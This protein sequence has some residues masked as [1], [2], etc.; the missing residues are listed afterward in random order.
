MG[1]ALIVSSQG[2]G[3]Y[4]AKLQPDRTSYDRQHL[5]LS[6][7]IDDIT[8]TLDLL[9]SQIDEAKTNE[10][11][12][13]DQLKNAI[14][15]NS[16]N[17]S[18]LESAWRSASS[19]LL[20]L[21]QTQNSL[22]LQ[23]ASFELRRDELEKNAPDD[24]SEV[25]L[26]CADYTED[27]SG[28][29]GTIDP[30]GD[31]SLGTIIKPGDRSPVWVQGDGQFR[32]VRHM[33]PSELF[34]NAAMLPAWQKWT[35]KYRIGTITAL[36]GDSCNVSLEP[37]ESDA[38]SINVNQSETLENV[39]ID[40]MD[41]NGAAF[42]VGDTCVVMFQ[43]SEWANPQV[44][45]FESNPKACSFRGFILH[46]HRVLNAYFNPWES[47]QLLL[48]KTGSLWKNTEDA[49]ALSVGN[50][51][52]QGYAG[53]LSWDSSPSRYWH[54]ENQ[55]MTNIFY[56]NDVPYVGDYYDWSPPPGTNRLLSGES[57]GWYGR[58]K[59]FKG[60]SAIAEVNSQ[61]TS[62]TLSPDG[63]RC[64]ITL[65]G[66]PENVY[67]FDIDGTVK[68]IAEMR[69]VAT[70]TTFDYADV[71]SGLT[72]EEVES[73]LEQ[74]MTMHWRFNASG[75]IGI[76]ERFGTRQTM[77]VDWDNETVSVEAGTETQ[78]TTRYSKT[79]V[80]SQSF[81]PFD[82]LGDP[83]YQNESQTIP[84]IV[85]VNKSIKFCDW[86]GDDLVEAV[87]DIW[88]I[89]NFDWTKSTSTEWMASGT[90]DQFDGA[91]LTIDG[92]VVKTGEEVMFT[93]SATIGNPRGLSRGESF[94]IY[95]HQID[96]R[97]DSYSI[98]NMTFGEVDSDVYGESILHTANV[99][100]T[101][102]INNDV[103]TISGS[104]E[105]NDRLRWYDFEAPLTIYTEFSPNPG[106]SGTST[107]E[108]VRL[109]A[110]RI[111][112]D[113]IFS[114]HNGQGVCG[115]KIAT[116]TTYGPAPDR[117]KS[118]SVLAEIQKFPCLKTF[119]FSEGEMLRFYHNVD[120]SKIQETKNFTEIAVI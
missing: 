28:E 22:I 49:S 13:Y 100:N 44:I 33:T 53:S 64:L 85:T 75:T 62:A 71:F 112:R 70:Y 109:S 111:S 104:A 32:D 120:S 21:Q 46:N 25:D 58:L 42:E 65:G 81:G 12:A 26:W 98:D 67:I 23:K 24:A 37:V 93:N 76:T 115:G 39:G 119:T 29:V 79:S 54:I 89:Q 6:N 31:L 86:K 101:T 94:Q 19:I 116:L 45:G 59:V 96:L 110:A 108:L 88:Q 69:H 99:T 63:A 106:P 27:L 9:S 18:A 2:G 16:E 117:V 38:Q 74:V 34:Y 77:L 83:Y 55:M 103:S 87:V 1:K 72:P 10:T 68:T 73:E 41:C 66:V 102:S 97:S 61:I 90:L 35:P 14:V 78:I 114:P 8:D 43:G 80:I 5:M 105:L 107:S 4:K 50:M 92:V 40:Y 95:L 51:D 52:W 113:E 84:L 91:T 118:L 36:N 82:D 20:G 3:L 48:R 57:A 11:I 17:I 60:G 15:N 30:A 47:N 56:P 7:E